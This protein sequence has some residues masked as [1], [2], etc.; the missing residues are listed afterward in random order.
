M[1]SGFLQWKTLTGLFLSC[2][3]G[4]LQSRTGLFVAFLATVQQQLAIGLGQ[5]QA[6]GDVRRRQGRP[7]PGG[8]DTGSSDDD[9]EEAN[10]GDEGGPCPLG[11]PLV[12]E[13]LPDSF[14]RRQFGG[15]FEMLHDAGPQV[16]LV[17]AKQVR[18]LALRGCC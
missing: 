4:P 13:L 3:R 5:R 16:P 9:D 15:F 7:G 2:E 11:L 17:L 14:L 8:D 1:P 6:E 18:D 12:E 10:G